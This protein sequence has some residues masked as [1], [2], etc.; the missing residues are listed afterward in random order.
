LVIAQFT[1]VARDQLALWQEAREVS[2]MVALGPDP[3]V[4]AEEL[5]GDGRTIAV[6]NGA[7]VVALTHRTRLTF[8]GFAFLHRTITLRARVSMAL[9]PPLAFEGDV[10]SDKFDPPGP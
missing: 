8:A 10:G 6:G 7:V 5:S 2:R 4:V 9:E 1:I 3:L